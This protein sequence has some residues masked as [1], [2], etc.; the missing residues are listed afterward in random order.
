MS[1]SSSFPRTSIFYSY[2]TAL[3]MRAILMIDR[4]LGHLRT[5]AKKIPV[6]RLQQSALRILFYHQIAKEKETRA[7][8]RES[9]GNQ[10]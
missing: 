10:K 9:P 7:M 5:I 8:Q 3:Y 1:Y 2:T 4:Q 6:D